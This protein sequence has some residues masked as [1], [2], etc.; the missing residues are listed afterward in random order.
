VNI[1]TRYPIRRVWRINPRFRLD[2][3]DNSNNDSTQWTAAPSLRIDYRWRR[4]YRFVIEGGGE[5]ST[6]ELTAETQDTSSYLFSLG[7][8]ADF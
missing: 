5:W 6:Q 8:R 4:R 7:Y 2:Y 1:D 3:R